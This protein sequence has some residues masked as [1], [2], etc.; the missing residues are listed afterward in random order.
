MSKLD[1]TPSNMPPSPPPSLADQVLGEDANGD[2]LHAPPPAHAEAGHLVRRWDIESHGPLLFRDATDWQSSRQDDQSLIV[3]GSRTTLAWNAWVPP[4]LW[5]PLRGR[6]RLTGHDLSADLRPGDMLITEHGARITAQASTAQPGH[7][8][9]IVLDPELLAKVARSR[10]AWDADEIPGFTQ[11]MR[12]DGA[13]IAA[14]RSLAIS[15][16]DAELGAGVQSR[17]ISLIESLLLD[18]AD[19]LRRVACCPGR[20]LRARVL[21]ARRLARALCHVDSNLGQEAAIVRLAEVARMSPPYFTRVFNQVIRMTPH[22]YVVEVRLAA[23]RRLLEETDHSMQELCRRLGFENRCA[24]ARMFKQ[25]YG[26]AP[27][28]HRRHVRG[29]GSLKA[30][31]PRPGSAPSLKA[32]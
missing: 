23:A 9:A 14:A 26:I 27:T 30:P 28:A 7:A 1:S 18:Q 29:L 3:I 2:R 22:R 25:F 8:V 20:T 31:A 24:F 32:Q 12:G 15:T 19:W 5:F 6:L 13:A 21:L 11:L 16:R 17:L 10:F 4:T